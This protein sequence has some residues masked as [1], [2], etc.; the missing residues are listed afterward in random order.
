MIKSTTSSFSLG[1]LCET[2]ASSLE[3]FGL[4]TVTRDLKAEAQDQSRLELFSRL[5][6]QL[7]GLAMERDLN[8]ITEKSNEAT[9]EVLNSSHPAS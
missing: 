4:E 2:A 9:E 7:D 5:K 1:S 8:V 6:S 3:S